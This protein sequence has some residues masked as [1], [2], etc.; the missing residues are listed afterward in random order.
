[1]REAGTRGRSPRVTG[2]FAEIRVVGG[3]TDGPQ[4]DGKKRR[5]SFHVSSLLTLGLYIR[6]DR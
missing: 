1:M 4:M 6:R 3:L 5:K 2:P